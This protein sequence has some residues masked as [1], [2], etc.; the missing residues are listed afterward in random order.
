[1]GGATAAAPALALAQGVDGGR[2]PAF[3][4][5]AAMSVVALIVIRGRLPDLPGAA[6]AERP[7]QA[8]IGL[9]ALGITASVAGLLSIGR[10]DP[11]RVGV[12]LAGA[13]ILVVATG[14]SRRLVRAGSSAPVDIRAVTVVLAVG[15][16]VGFA[17][18]APTLQL[19][20][21][22]QFVEDFPPLLATAAIAPFVLALLLAGPVSGILLARFQPRLLVSA[23]L[24]AMGLADVGDV[25]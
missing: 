12:V 20:M 2:W 14:L 4:A 25:R 10:I 19:P 24:V 22:F 15:V 13:A 7:W 16:V 8:I 1:M 9:W 11:I 23:G 5:C 17:Q 21:F 18:V 3:L 6:L